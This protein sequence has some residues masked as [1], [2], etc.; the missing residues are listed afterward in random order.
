MNVE[1]PPWAERFRSDDLDE[2]RERLS[3]FGMHRRERRGRGRLRYHHSLVRIGGSVWGWRGTSLGQVIR[4][5]TSQA[6]LHLP[7]D[8]RV[9]YRV[10]PT[11]VESSPDNVVLLS[12]GTEYT[13]V[14]LGGSW[15]GAQ[16]DGRRLIDELVR[17]GGSR[18]IA[19]GSSEISL[20]PERLNDLTRL[21]ADAATDEPLH[22]TAAAD[23]EA[24]LISW[25]ADA[26]MP[27]EQSRSSDTQLARQRL[28]EDWIDGHLGETITLGRLCAVAGVGA[29][30]LQKSFLHY[31]GQTPMEWVASRR[32]AAARLILFEG[33]YADSVTAVALRC[34]LSHLG[35]FAVTYKRTYGE[36][37]STTFLR[38]RLASA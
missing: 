26:L 27:H 9:T 2:I 24:R 13:A 16:V 12:P 33:E 25:I 28:V 22:E 7:I 23:L 3:R 6:L 11:L 10:G 30:S 4:A 5:E 20:D 34:G 8:G 15:L 37:P 36:S 21:F 38:R 1:P 17:R 29:R 32:L 14:S 35:R 19:A 31:R 18:A